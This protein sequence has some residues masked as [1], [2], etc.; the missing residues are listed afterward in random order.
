VQFEVNKRKFGVDVAF[1]EAL[2]TTKLETGS[3]VP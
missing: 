2:Y 3:K 1:D